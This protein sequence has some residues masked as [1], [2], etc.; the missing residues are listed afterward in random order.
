MFT[1]YNRNRIKNTLGCARKTQGWE[2]QG[3]PVKKN[4]QIII[5]HLKSMEQ[6]K[7]H[8]DYPLPTFIRITSSSRLECLCT[9][10]FLVG[11]IPLCKSTSQH[12]LTKGNDKV[13]YPQP[14]KEVENLHSKQVPVKHKT[15]VEI[16]RLS[17]S[18]KLHLGRQHDPLMFQYTTVLCCFLTAFISFIQHLMTISLSK[19]LRASS[20]YPG[21]DEQNYDEGTYTFSWY[22]AKTQLALVFG[23]LDSKV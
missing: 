6:L 9:Y 12:T 18:S 4:K 14:T 16:K 2:R 23:C 11:K 13:H 8:T 3:H 17:T 15:K 22:P 1:V 7:S 20:G 19:K 21:I 5:G 10:L